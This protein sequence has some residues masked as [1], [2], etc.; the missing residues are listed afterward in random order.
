M[1]KHIIQVILKFTIK[2]QKCFIGYSNREIKIKKLHLFYICQEVQD[3]V[4]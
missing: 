2:V 3:E 4:K 1:D